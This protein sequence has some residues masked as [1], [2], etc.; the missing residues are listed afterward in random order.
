M[1]IQL[2]Q[3]QKDAANYLARSRS[4]EIV[5][6]QAIAGSGKTKYLEKFDTA[7]VGR[8]LYSSFSKSLV[9]EA[10]SIFPKEVTVK[11]FDA[12]CYTEVVK[13]GIGGDKYGP[14]HV[15]NFSFRNVTNELEDEQRV[16][17][18]LIM[19]LFFGSKYTSIRLFLDEAMLNG[20]HINRDLGMQ[21]VHHIKQM[22][23]KQRPVTF[24]FIKKW[25]HICLFRK[26]FDVE[27]YEAIYFDEVQDMEACGLEIFK[28]LPAKRKVVVGDF[29]QAI[30]SSF[31]HTVNGFDYLK[32]HISKTFPLT[33]SFRVNVT[34]AKLVQNFMRATVDSNFIFTGHD[35]HDTTI[36]TTGY[37]ARTNSAV[38]AKMLE[39]EAEGIEYGLARKVGNLF[40]LIL[41]LI[42]MKKD[43]IID[44]EYSYLNKDISDFHSIP[45]K[46]LAKG[47]TVFKY[48]MRKHSTNRALKSAGSLVAKHGSK[49][50]YNLWVKAKAMEKSRVKPNL[51]VGTVFGFKGLT[52]DFSQISPDLNLD[53][54][55]DSKLSN[56]EKRSEILIRY[57]A[58][59]RH[60]I[61][62]RGAE[63]MNNYAIT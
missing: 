60:R 36:R 43:N 11:T 25:Y 44:G 17:V 9:N 38:I 63:W 49:T 14:R 23:N 5:A 35:H 27:P 2:S 31:T 51:I 4:G 61:A 62:I 59:S 1:G 39:L 12:Y 3:E 16:E 48:V 29:Y 55:Q 42:S 28:L 6:V 7:M 56:E 15:G 34:D 58:I 40:S 53:F 52:V 18:V 37:I 41:T 45:A 19:E 46:K 26:Q 24:G 57:V 13:Y 20:K 33:Q 10:E 32:D 8:R 50:L 47:D 22:I 21:A 54:L 30:F